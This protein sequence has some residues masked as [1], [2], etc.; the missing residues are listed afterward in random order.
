MGVEIS[1]N[2]SVRG[3]CLG[4]RVCAIGRMR[5]IPSSSQ[6]MQRSVIQND[7]ILLYPETEIQAVEFVQQG[8]VLEEDNTFISFLHLAPVHGVGLESNRHYLKISRNEIEIEWPPIASSVHD[9]LRSWRRSRSSSLSR[10]R[11]IQRL[12]PE[13]M[14]QNDNK[15]SVSAHQLV[16]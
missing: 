5:A 16:Q 14:G 6:I 4:W 1:G 9:D 12:P 13:G 15:R 8:L 11:G 7:G 10:D 3:C 2:L